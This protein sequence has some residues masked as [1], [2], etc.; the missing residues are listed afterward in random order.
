LLLASLSM[1]AGL[2]VLLACGCA[3]SGPPETV[4]PAL[5]AEGTPAGPDDRLFDGCR[6][7][8]TGDRAFDIR[9]DH[10][11]LEVEPSRHRRLDAALEA[12]IQSHL[13]GGSD[14]SDLET[15]MQP[16]AL[17]V[18]GSRYQGRRFRRQ[19]PVLPGSADVGFLVAAEDAEGRVLLLACSG[20]EV[21]DREIDVEDGC[22][23]AMAHV[24]RH[25]V[26]T[27]LLE[28]APAADP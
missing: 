24:V 20:R 19:N 25:G 5:L 18:D 13:H 26:P 14:D 28:E 1:R 9:C 3:P 8:S 2:V 7:A 23:R 10:F 4:P 21:E 17:A 6:A 12:A 16:F 22:K 27:R 11:A 15:T